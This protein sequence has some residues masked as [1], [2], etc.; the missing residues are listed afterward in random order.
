MEN[1]HMKKIYFTDYKDYKYNH[2]SGWPYAISYLNDLNT[3]KGIFFDSFLEKNFG[4][5]NSLKQPKIYKE[6]W[7]GV[8]H[9][10]DN[11]PEWFNDK[12]TPREIF[13][14]KYFI[15]SL[16]NCKGFFCL[17]EYEKNILKKY[18]D[19]PINV[20]LHPTEKPEV[21]FSME[22]YLNNENREIIQ[23]GVFLRKLSSIFLLPVKKIK[24][25][26]LGM[27]RYNFYQLKQEEKELK[28]KVDI[29]DVKF[30]KFLNN[31]EYD[32]VLSK[33]IAFMD[34]Y[35]TSANNAVIEC[36]VRNTPLLINQHPAVIEYLGEAYPFYFSS[37]EEAAKKAEDLELIKETTL[38]LENLQTKNKLTGESFLKTIIDSEIYNDMQMGKINKSAYL[39]RLFQKSTYFVFIW[40]NYL[41]DKIKKTI[42]L[43]SPKLYFKIKKAMLSLKN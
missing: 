19:L 27:G 29:K 17:S 15:E 35:D 38:Y 31:Q 12:Q 7:I 21:K 23:L 1:S 32:E 25:S 5:G 18:T 3:L 20:V 41:K 24:K 6:P 40:I 42:L 43:S 14:N 22:K 26:A 30:Y 28:I 4:W 34:L 11:V 2:R 9:V 36:M 8:F 39:K 13:K 33:N 10:P 16:K 37:L